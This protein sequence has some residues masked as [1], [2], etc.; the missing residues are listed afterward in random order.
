[1]RTVALLC[2][3]V[4]CMSPPED[5]P[6]LSGG[7]LAALEAVRSCSLHE[8]VHRPI[9]SYNWTDWLDAADRADNAEALL[10][11]ELELSGVV[12]PS[13]ECPDLEGLI[14]RAMDARNR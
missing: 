6:E 12:V 4:G 3:V 5:G 14:D 7:V 10:F 13:G 2:A 11:Y 9:E 8:V 1:M